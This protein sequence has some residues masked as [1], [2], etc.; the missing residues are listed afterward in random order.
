[1]AGEREPEPPPV[2]IGQAGVAP[3]A[4]FRILFGEPIEHDFAV[5][6]LGI[7]L[8]GV[9]AKAALI[10]GAVAEGE[11]DALE[12]GLRQHMAVGERDVEGGPDNLDAGRRGLLSRPRGRPRNRQR[13]EDRDPRS[14]A[15]R[16]CRAGSRT[17]STARPFSSPRREPVGAGRHGLLQQ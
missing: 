12:F 16:F 4:A 6:I 11:D 13:G 14:R 15:A 7:A 2:G 10:S 5:R 8:D 17:D 9:D 3:L 1:M